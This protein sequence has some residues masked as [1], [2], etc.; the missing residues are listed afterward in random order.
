MEPY[1]H[2]TTSV[3]CTGAVRLS[4]MLQAEKV[5]APSNAKNESCTWHTDIAPNKTARDRAVCAVKA[6]L[7]Y[8]IWL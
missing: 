5:P 6:R 1:G 2:A 3:A 7:R 4:L 8:D